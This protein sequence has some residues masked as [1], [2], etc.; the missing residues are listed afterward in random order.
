MIRFLESTRHRPRMVV[1][2]AAKTTLRWEMTTARPSRVSTQTKAGAR[3]ILT[4]RMAA[5]LTKMRKVR[6]ARKKK[7]LSQSQQLQAKCSSPH[8][9]MILLGFRSKVLPKVAKYATIRDEVRLGSQ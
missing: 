2:V 7:M 5:F 4:V 8:R 3:Q 6:Q 1:V 9:S